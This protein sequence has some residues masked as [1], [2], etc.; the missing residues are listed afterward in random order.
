MKSS[1]DKTQTSTLRKVLP[2]IL[3]TVEVFLNDFSLQMIDI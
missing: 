1:Q 3:P 2:Y